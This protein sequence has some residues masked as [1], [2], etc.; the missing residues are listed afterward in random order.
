MTLLMTNKKFWSSNGTQ[1]QQFWS[2]VVRHC[3]SIVEPLNF[4]K[5]AIGRF[6]IDH[7][8]HVYASD[9]SPPGHRKPPKIH[10]RP[11][12]TMKFGWIWQF[13]QFS[14]SFS[15]DFPSKH[16]GSWLRHGEV[17]DL[18]LAALRRWMATRKWWM[19][20]K[21]GRYKWWWLMMVNDG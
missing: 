21:Y 5:E 11:R 3:I 19:A 6:N 16:H 13:P 9:D 4:Q 15:H 1:W 20:I 8:Q 14:P 10:Q 7:S 12:K 17:D 2:E 18:A